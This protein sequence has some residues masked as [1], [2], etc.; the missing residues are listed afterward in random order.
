MFTV[1]DNAGVGPVGL[2]SVDRYALFGDSTLHFTL[3]GQCLELWLCIVFTILLIG[4]TA[5]LDDA[6]RMALRRRNI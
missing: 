1:M 5:S 2:G 6:R 4:N 3:P